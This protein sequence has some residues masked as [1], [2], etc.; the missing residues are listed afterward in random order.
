M[1]A[2]RGVEGGG[3]GEEEKVLHIFLSFIIIAIPA[4]V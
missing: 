4:R 2:P 1:F 3:G